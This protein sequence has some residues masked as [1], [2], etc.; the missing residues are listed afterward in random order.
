M[1]SH[2]PG[3]PKQGTWCGTLPKAALWNGLRAQHARAHL[4][5]PA[6]R[7]HS[8]RAHGIKRKNA[9][10][11]GGTHLK[12]PLNSLC[13]PYLPLLPP[14]LALYTLKRAARIPA[15]VATCRLTDAAIRTAS[16]PACTISRRLPLL[17]PWRQLVGA[18]Q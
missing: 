1:R 4:S 9:P 12:Q 2:P 11:V 18:S 10:F 8:E 16:A 15:G 17:P 14:L 3:S 13:A 6:P 5:S 7:W